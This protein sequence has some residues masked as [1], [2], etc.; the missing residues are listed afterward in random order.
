MMNTIYMKN[1]SPFLVALL[2]TM[3]GSSFVSCKKQ[4]QPVAILSEY[5]KQDKFSDL[6]AELIHNRAK[7]NGSSLLFYDIILNSVMNRPQESNRLIDKF[8]YRFSALDDTV[9]YYL[10][11]SEYNNYLKLCNYGKLKTIGEQLIAKYKDFIDSSAYVELKDDNV[12]YGFLINEKPISL[13]KKSDTELKVTKDLAGYTLMPIRGSND[14]T[15]NLIFDTGAN[16]NTL[17]RSA[18][19]KL[20]L[21]MIPNS[22]IYVMGSTGVRNKAEIGMADSL[23]IGHITIQH[24]EF[25]VFPDS[26]FTFAGGRYVINGTVGFPIFSRFEEIIY[27]DSTVF[28]PRI[29]TLKTGEPNMF[30]K[31]DDYILAVGYK[32][33]KYPFF[34]DTGNDKSYFTK[35]FY[36]IDSASFQSLKDTIYSFGGI[37][38]QYAIKAKLADEMTVNYSGRNFKLVKPMIET[39]NG[40][41]DKRMYGS[42]GKD[43]MN[44]YKKRIMSFKE[45]RL[46]FE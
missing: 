15:V 38:G 6:Y 45:A 35:N 33:K 1:K 41:L 25:V 43:F 22:V 40:T 37:G 34:F 17:T 36:A 24:A 5:V 19:K 39:E 27:T 30:I 11:Q 26:L 12:R 31:S 44:L 4:Y 3:A 8:R 18:A 10:T 32:D 16:V 9:N 23:T 28:I 42:I 2:L 46:E 14:S 7:Y 20:N 29:P 21:R 13:I